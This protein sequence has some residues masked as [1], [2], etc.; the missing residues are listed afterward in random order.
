MSIPEFPL[1]SRPTHKINFREPDVQ[2]GMRFCDI[3]E[4]FEENATTEYLNLLQIGTLSD[5]R[6]WTAQDRRTALWWIYLFSQTD[7]TITVKYDCSHCGEA[8]Y[9]DCDMRLLDEEATYLEREPSI[10]VTMNAAGESYEWLLV[11]LNGVAMENLEKMRSRLPEDIDSA[12]YKRG[13]A[14]L[15]IWELVYQARLFYD[16]DPAFDAAANRRYDLVQTMS[17]DIEF[18]HF[19][20]R[21]SQAQQVLKH[22]LN[23]QFD[24]GRAMLILP[25]HYCDADKAKEAGRPYTRLLLG[26]RNIFFLPNS[27][28]DWL[29]DFSEQPDPIRWPVD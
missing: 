17:L 26:F 11:P 10:Q 1:P 25:K 21:I 8:H 12:E 29:A 16:L 4:A 20:A 2:T 9:Y 23:M 28:Y 7:P 3:N 19:V 22:G 18:I 14:D 27:G 24:D 5:S 6:F 13:L 15:R